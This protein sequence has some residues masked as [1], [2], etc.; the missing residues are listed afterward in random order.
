MSSTDNRLV[1]LL[2]SDELLI[3]SIY[4]S[5]SRHMD[6]EN[7]RRL[8]FCNWPH[9]NYR[10]TTPEAMAQAGF[11]HLTRRC[12]DQ[13]LCFISV[14]SSTASKDFIATCTLTGDV[15]IWDVSSFNRVSLLHIRVPI[16]CSSGI[17]KDKFYD[18]LI[19]L[20]WRAGSSDIV[21]VTGD[22]NTQ[23]GSLARLRLTRVVGMDWSRY[24]RTMVNDC[25]SCAYSRLFLFSNAD[26]TEV[27]WPHGTLQQRPNYETKLI[28]SPSII[29]GA[30]QKLTTARLGTHVDSEQALVRGRFAI[31]FP[32]PL[33][34]QTNRLETETGGSGCQTNLPQPSSGVF[35][36]CCTI[37]YEL[38]LGGD[39]HDFAQ[40]W[41]FCLW[42]GATKPTQV[43]DIRPNSGTT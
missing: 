12:G 26:T 1:R 11:Y 42:Y 41:E 2:I 4:F 15:T 34:M 32:G 6:V 33:N 7:Y 24:L 9:T 13:V 20:L 27:V 3:A 39:Y 35:S 14:L 10:W 40:Y 37:G 38:V 31:R 30:D 23:V 8:T 5:S 18:A 19:V 25:F 43:L 36:N 28:A 16:D 29:D 22:L 21:V 17:I